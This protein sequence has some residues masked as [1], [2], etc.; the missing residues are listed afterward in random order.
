MTNAGLAIQKWP[1]ADGTQNLMKLDLAQEL[2]RG[3]DLV[4]EARGI[5]ERAHRVPSARM[6]VYGQGHTTSHPWA[7]MIIV[8]RTYGDTR[9]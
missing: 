7:P 3:R 8:R 2:S 6:Q 4:T 9:E 5:A 1:S